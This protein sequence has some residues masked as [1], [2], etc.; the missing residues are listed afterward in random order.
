MNIEHFKHLLEAKRRELLGEIA[1]L[2]EEARGAGG[3][4]VR[5]I[6][7]DAT[8][9]QASGQALEQETLASQSLVQV[10]DALKR[11]ENGTYGKCIVCG[12]PIPLARLEA[13]PWAAYCLEHQEKHD[14]ATHAP[15][16]GSKI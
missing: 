14:R 11:I 13:V 3:A 1:D 10:E 15:K 7:D 12:K 9:A 8:S 2:K 16:G 5:D 4:E 6:T